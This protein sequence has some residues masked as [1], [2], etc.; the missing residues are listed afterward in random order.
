MTLT[1]HISLE[2]LTRSDTAV[3]LGF[4]NKPPADLV[5]N[6]AD[7][8]RM[9]ERIRTHLC[10]IAGYDVPIHISSGYRCLQ[11]NRA[12]KS[13]DTSAHVQGLAVDWT[14]PDFGSPVEICE[15]L[16][17][18]VG[19]LKIGQLIHEFGRWVHTGVT[20]P[21]KPVNRILTISAAGTVPG[22]VEV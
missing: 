21:D 16:A 1:D 11:L 13:S 15:A 10:D 20:M 5:P 7:T 12:L 18:H 8:A 14:A 9:L 2:E 4:D 3:R 17:P 6:L 19:S 22:I